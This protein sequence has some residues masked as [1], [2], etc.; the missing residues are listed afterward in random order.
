MCSATSSSKVHS[1]TRL[2]TETVTFNLSISELRFTWLAICS[3]YAM[4]AVLTI[5][6]HQMRGELGKMHRAISHLTKAA[7]EKSCRLIR[8]IWSVVTAIVV[9]LFNR[10]NPIDLNLRSFIESRLLRA[11]SERSVSRLRA[12]RLKM[13]E[14]NADETTTCFIGR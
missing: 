14:E 13:A 12:F 3:H 9:R 1:C 8:L 6:I 5:G 4:L 7:F 10:I 11:R 2:G